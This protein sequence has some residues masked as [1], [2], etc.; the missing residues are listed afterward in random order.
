MGM[1]PIFVVICTNGK[2]YISNKVA[3]A[4]GTLFSGSTVLV[5][6]R[7]NPDAVDQLVCTLAGS[8]NSSASALSATSA[9]KSGAQEGQEI[10]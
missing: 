6:Y 1:T 3:N 7:I 10:H 9:S 4:G 8:G 5:T 2:I